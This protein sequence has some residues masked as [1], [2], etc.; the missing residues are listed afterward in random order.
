[1]IRLGNR[2][3]DRPLRKPRACGDDPGTARSAYLNEL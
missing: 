2:L 1:M 3:R